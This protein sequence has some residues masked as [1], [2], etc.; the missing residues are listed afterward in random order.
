MISV[1]IPSAEFPTYAD[2]RRAKQR[3]H[4]AAWKERNA[5]AYA[6]SENARRKSKYASDEE[7][8]QKQ[9]ARALAVYRAA[10]EKTKA[11][12]RAYIAANPEKIRTY[13]R[14]Y[15]W[16]KR[17]RMIH[18]TPAWADLTEIREFYRAARAVGM[19]VDHV[20]PIAGENV[21]GL[22]VRGNLQMLTRSANAS[23]GNSHAS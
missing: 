17:R 13:F 14:E 4:R 8:A 2:Y 12:N 5:V 19:E 10:P 3:E 22:H 15:N 16:I 1:Y 9:R 11:R 21:C 7:Y 23:K 6:A 20:V 18:A